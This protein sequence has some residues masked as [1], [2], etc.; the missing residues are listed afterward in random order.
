MIC[1]VYRLN[2]LK[3]YKYVVVLSKYDGKILLSRHK[4]RT[5]WET[6]GGHIEKGET[7]L[8]AAKRE[9]YEESGAEEY[10]IEPLCDYWAGDE[11]TGIG[12][13]GVVF[14]AEIR[15]LGKIP[16]SEMAEV[17]LFDALPDNLTYPAIT[18]KLFTY[19]QENVENSTGSELSLEFRIAETE[20][21]QEIYSLVKFAVE[22]MEKRKI[23]QWDD[24]YPDKEILLNDI[25]KQQLFVGLLNNKIAVIYVL[26]QECD[27]EYKNGKWNC[28]NASYCVIHRLCVNPA[29]QNKG[30]GRKTMEHIEKE[31]VGEGI[32]SVRLDVFTENPYA[33][34]LYE[35]LNYVKVGTADWRKGRFYLMEKYLR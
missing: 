4:D 10:E 7:P 11:D 5:T 31:L 17:K 15:K 14:T 8:D 26:N 16:E 32:E 21:L 33:L 3:T 1:G 13:G 2:Q 28:E 20:D 23:Y 27:E 24:V 19:L 18:P 9:L 22:N 34:K 29:F 25:K 30:I 35:R 12:S 6:Q